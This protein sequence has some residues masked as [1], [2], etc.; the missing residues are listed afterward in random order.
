MTSHPPPAQ[1]DSIVTWLDCRTEGLNLTTHGS[2]SP[3]R[4]ARTVFYT[5]WN[6][7]NKS[8]RAGVEPSSSL[9]SSMVM[10]VDTAEAAPAMDAVIKVFSSL[11]EQDYFSPWRTKNAQ[12][13]TGSAFVINSLDGE[14]QLL[15]TNAHVVDSAS[16]IQVRRYG[17]AKKFT[18][19]S[20][21]VAH[22]CDLALLEVKDEEFW[23]GLPSLELHKDA[24]GEP[25]LP[26]L[27]VIFMRVARTAG[28]LD[29]KGGGSCCWLPNRRRLHLRI[30]RC[31]VAH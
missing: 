7:L 20:R 10:A 31:R 29:S 12:E 27:Q 25:S 17:S 1:R 14:S 22:D 2:R 23:E 3:P 5:M 26:S 19:V 13:C 30:A 6:A 21:V 28:S 24:A 15:V 11:C 18:A 9:S 8:G 4:R 16:F